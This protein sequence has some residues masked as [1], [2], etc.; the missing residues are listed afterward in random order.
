MTMKSNSNLNAILCSWLGFSDIN[1]SEKENFPFE[2]NDMG[3][4]ARTLDQN[5]YKTLLLLDDHKGQMGEKYQAKL[6]GRLKLKKITCEIRLFPVNLSGPTTIG[7]IYDKT[8]N[9]LDTYKKNWDPSPKFTFLVSSGTPAMQATWMFLS[10]K[11]DACLVESSREKGVLPADLPFDLQIR[12]PSPEEATLQDFS[13]VPSH[14][15]ARFEKEM[16]SKSNSM[17]EV[18]EKIGIAAMTDH[19]VVILGESG[20]GKELVAKWIHNLS[21]R[22][23]KPILAVN[24]GAFSS[25]LLGS[26]LFGHVKGAFTS[27]DQ[28]TIGKFQASDGGTIFL[29][30]IGEMPKAQQVYLLRVLQEKVIRKIGGNRDIPVNCRVIA[31]TNKDIISEVELGAFREDLLYRLMVLMIKIPPLRKR[32]EDIQLL[33]NIFLKDENQRRKKAGLIPVRMD[34]TAKK[35]ISDYHWP[36]NVRELINTLT[37]VVATARQTVL[38]AEHIRTNLLNIRAISKK[39]VAPSNRHEVEDPI[40]TAHSGALNR[41]MEDPEF[42]L[43]QIIDEVEYHYVKKALEMSRG[44]KTGAARILYGKDHHANIT[45]KIKKLAVKYPDLLIDIKIRKKMDSQPETQ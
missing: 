38:T 40:L 30:E 41:S 32:G 23:G 14:L 1:A 6:A 28:E 27:A 45:N 29:D 20:T 17:K 43:N 39:N 18:K 35:A 34:L 9:V 11:Y 21:K 8:K 25:E 37:R 44:E 19:P 12:F 24:C 26:E 3:P 13:F 33:S 42:N 36:G 10:T 2:T 22:S 5:Q 31:A 16:I 4:I 15:Q 7:D